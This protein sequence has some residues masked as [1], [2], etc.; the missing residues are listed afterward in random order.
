M[1]N[2]FKWLKKRKEDKKQQ[3]EL[4]LKEEV[5]KTRSRRETMLKN[6][7]ERF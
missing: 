2:L 5:E 6:E 1:I 7:Y 4:V 3:R